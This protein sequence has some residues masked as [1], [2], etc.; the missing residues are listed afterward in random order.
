M[1]YKISPHKPH[2]GSGSKHSSKS[3]KSGNGDANRHNYKS[4]LQSLQLDGLS[5]LFVVNEYILQCGIN[6]PFTPDPWG[7]IMPPEDPWHY[8]DEIVGTVFRWQ[9]GNITPATDYVWYRPEGIHPTNGTRAEG[10][11]SSRYYGQCE[12]YKTFAVF[13]CWRPLPCVY[14]QADPMVTPL[15]NLGAGEHWS[16]MGFEDDDGTGL[17]RIAADR[18]VQVVAGRN[19]SWL[20]GLIPNTFENLI[21]GTPSNG[22]G[23]ELAVIIGRV[24]LQYGQND[25]DTPFRG[26][27]WK[28]GVWQSPH[29]PADVTG[30]GALRGVLVHIALDPENTTHSTFAHLQTFE[31][32]ARIVEA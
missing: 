8:S 26:G 10:Y 11:I 18:G 32:N 4:H 6:A 3:S 16:L 23:G 30:P 17:T 1:S 12:Q 19:P 24:A 28:Y 14:A 25:T 29:N 7:S 15:G 31:Q 27:K 13:N 5:F 20:P 21:T 9:D 22:L 2:H